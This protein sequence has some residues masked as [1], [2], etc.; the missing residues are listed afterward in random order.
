MLGDFLVDSSPPPRTLQDEV[1]GSN[2]TKGGC[3]LPLQQYSLQKR[4]GG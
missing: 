4:K 3:E 1:G 2:K